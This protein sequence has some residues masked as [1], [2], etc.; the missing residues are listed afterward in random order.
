LLL[1]LACNLG[2]GS[3]PL[4][5][6][7]APES[8]QATQPSNDPSQPTENITTGGLCDN[9]L[10]P[11]KQGATWT[12]LS[13]GSPSGDFSYTDTIAE[14]RADGFTLTSQFT[15]LTRTQ[16]WA[17]ETGGLKAL[18]LGGAGAAASI[19]TQ[20]TTAEFTSSDITGISLPKEITPGM[21]WEYSLKMQGVTAMPGNQNAQSTGT[22]SM[23][24]QEIGRESV[25]VPAGTFEAVKL[26]STSLVQ[27]TADFQGL[28]VP[29]T[30]NGSSFVWY[31]PGV[32]YIKSVENSDYGGTAFT[33]TTELQSYNIP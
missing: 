5:G 1:T 20:G 16:E 19:S 22:F 33:S 4:E 32:G 14:L 23:T 7:P 31:A 21:Q 28:Q 26:Q 25:T 27:I 6:Q 15:G 24:M 10:Y 2:S 8:D 9:A 17:C 13:T 3:A 30:I 11:V 29:V 18:E 12:Y